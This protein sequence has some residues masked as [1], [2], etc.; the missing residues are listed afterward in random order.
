VAHTSR[1]KDF[2]EPENP[3]NVGMTGVFGSEAG[4]HA[5]MRC[6]TLVLLGCDF[7]WRQL[8]PSDATII[9]IDIDGTHLGRRHPVSIGAVGDIAST[10]DALLPVIHA[11]KI[12]RFLKTVA[13]GIVKPAKASESTQRSMK[14]LFIRNTSPRPSRSMQ[15]MTRSIPRTAAPQWF[16]ACVIFPR[17]AE[18]ALC[19]R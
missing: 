12:T 4:Y 8:Y 3:Y 19:C 18:T 16:G 7:A 1:A 5:L 9:Q 10:L 14:G 15:R 2:V 11:K 13:N 6:N 17:R